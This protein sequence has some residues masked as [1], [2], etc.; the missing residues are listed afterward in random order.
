VKATSIDDAQ[1]RLKASHPFD[2]VMSAIETS[3]VASLLS[4]LVE[5]KRQSTPAA[6]SSTVDPRPG[7]VV[8]GLSAPVSDQAGST[9]SEGP[10]SLA[11]AAVIAE[12]CDTALVE[13]VRRHRGFRPR[14]VLEELELK[15]MKAFLDIATGTP[16]KI[17]GPVP[18]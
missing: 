12:D 18:F 1:A 7:F 14:M 17:L 4:G 13:C 15:A 16:K 3:E 5:L 6:T 8:I 10:D 2:A 9:P 11:F